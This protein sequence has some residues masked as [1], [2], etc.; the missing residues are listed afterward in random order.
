MQPTVKVHQIFW[1]RECSSFYR[2][3]CQYSF[4]E[5]T[6]IVKKKNTSYT[7]KTFS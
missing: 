3:R 1:L 7:R 5:Y 4:L 6:V 2:L